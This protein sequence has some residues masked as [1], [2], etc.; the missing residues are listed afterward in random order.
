MNYELYSKIGFEYVKSMLEC[1]SPYGAELVKKLSPVSSPD[2]LNAEFDNIS[3]VIKS[4]SP[5]IDRLSRLFMAIKDIR[6][7]IGGIGEGALDEVSLFEI[8]RYL[9][10]LKEICAAYSELDFALDGVLISPCAGALDILC[11]DGNCTAGFYITD[12]YSDALKEI[13]RQKREIEQKIRLAQGTEKDE[14]KLERLRIT[15]RESEE[16]LRIRHEISERLLPYKEDLLASTD[17]I[18]RIDFT[19][20]KACLAKKTGA[21]RPDVGADGLVMIDMRNPFVEKMLRERGRAFMPVSIKT[22]RGST[23][24]TGANM[25]GKSVALKT[26]ALNVCCAIC[27]LYS[28]CAEAHMPLFEDIIMIAEDS[29]NTENGLSSF[30]GE[31]IRLKNALK[32]TDRDVLLLFD[33]LARG[34]NP[35]EGARIVRSVVRYLNDK[36]AVSIFATHYDGVSEFAKKHYR[37]IGLRDFDFDTIEKLDGLDLISRSMDYGLYEAASDADCPREAIEIARL[38]LCGEEVLE[39]ILRQ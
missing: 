24:I 19:F 2:A 22:V 13:R 15:E 30:G 12:S 35:Q 29:E 32:Y 16:E 26:L 14:L 20:A 33:E 23:V 8:K 7:S 10:Q 9:L 18:G 4:S 11:I 39:E 34:T 5:M 17:A 1:S 3:R 37:V 6:R 27:G 25:G 31:L 28:F 21:C 36:R 38:L